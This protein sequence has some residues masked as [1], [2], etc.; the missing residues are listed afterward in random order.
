MDETKVEVTED[1]SEFVRSEVIA[2][3]DKFLPYSVDGKLGVMYKK[4]IV[5]ETESGPVYDPNKKAGVELFISLTFGE[6]VKM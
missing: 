2:A 6:D 1:W 4:S 3:L 5:E